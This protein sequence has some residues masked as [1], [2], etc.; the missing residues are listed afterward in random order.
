MLDFVILLSR[1]W[2]NTNL[3]I[4]WGHNF[5]IREGSHDILILNP[6]SVNRRTHLWKH[7]KVVRKWKIHLFQTR[8]CYIINVCF[9]NIFP[10]A[11]LRYDSHTT[12]CT[13]L[14]TTVWCLYIHTL[15]KPS[16]QDKLIQH[17]QSFLLSHCHLPNPTHPAPISRQ[18]SIYF[19][20]TTD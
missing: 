14:M 10:T 20:V 12:N 13:Y 18:P 6:K 1:I 7:S 15:M 4:F 8:R 19:F 17:P 3:L 5:C 2:C 9:K 11:L 16:H